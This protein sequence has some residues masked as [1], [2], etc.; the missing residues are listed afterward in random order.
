TQSVVPNFNL[1][2][3]YK[4]QEVVG[5]L[6]SAGFS[7]LGLLPLAGL[8]KRGSS[9]RAEGPTGRLTGWVIALAG[10]FLS[11]SAFFALFFWI[12][13]RYFADFLP[14]LFLLSV[15][16]SWQADRYFASRPRGRVLF[17]IL[18]LLTVAAS[19]I[20]SILL[21]ISL[22]ADGFRKLN[23]VLWRQLSNLFRP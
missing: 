12:A 23:P 20:V 3:G 1:P 13:E 16:G 2:A 6:F 19:L 5:L 10:V 21:S 9:L 7:L 17:W 11:S 22:N 18:L 14:G 8:L 15:L 4:A